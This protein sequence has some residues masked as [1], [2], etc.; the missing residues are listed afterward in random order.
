MKNVMQRLTMV[1][2]VAVACILPA[3]AQAQWGEP[4]WNSGG[5]DNAYGN[6]YG[7]GYGR[8]TGSLGGKGRF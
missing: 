2:T 6:G 5:Y 3:I 4:G 8:G 7:N 1:A